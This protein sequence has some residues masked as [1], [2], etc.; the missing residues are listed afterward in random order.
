MLRLSEWKIAAANDAYGTQMVLNESA[1]ADFNWDD[2]STG[3]SVF[4]QVMAGAGLSAQEWRMAADSG[5]GNWA[6]MLT[7]A[8]Q[9]VASARFAR[10]GHF[11]D[12]DQLTIGQ[13]SMTEVQQQA[14]FSLWSVLSAPL[15]IK[16][17]GT[18]GTT[19]AAIGSSS[20]DFTVILRGAPAVY[21]REESH[22][23][24]C[25]AERRSS[26]PGGNRVV[27][28]SRCTP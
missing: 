16:V 22:P 9:G 2:A 1:P 28:G 14:E 23:S 24:P 15:N 26:A 3:S 17:T 13:S 6:S 20:T 11:N 19:A 18:A 12:L 27:S 8:A 5:G 25:G 21:G 7:V 10:A 4:Q